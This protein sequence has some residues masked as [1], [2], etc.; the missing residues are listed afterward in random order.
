MEPD[1]ALEALVSWSK[2]T[3]GSCGQVRHGHRVR[4]SQGR[5]C[6]GGQLEDIGIGAGARLL[7]HDAL[8]VSQRADVVRET[9]NNVP[10][11]EIAV[12]WLSNAVNWVF[13]GVSM[14]CR[15]LT[16]EATVEL[17][18][19]PC[20]LVGDPK[21]RP[22]A[23]ISPSVKNSAAGVPRRWRIRLETSYR[24]SKNRQSDSR[25]SLS[26]GIG[27]RSSIETLSRKGLIGT[28]GIGFRV[29]HGLT[30]SSR[31][32]VRHAKRGALGRPSLVGR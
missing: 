30:D 21:F 4:S 12:S 7:R 20:P 18:S 19:N 29:H 8:Q 16:I 23:P 22:T 11:L 28:R 14:F 31:I 15:L 3:A 6:C 32:H 2:V 25:S 10:K 24:H 26:G 1:K 9:E 5:R 17:T 27:F 13:Q